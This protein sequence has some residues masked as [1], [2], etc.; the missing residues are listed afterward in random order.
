MIYD[1]CM[2]MWAI[3]II[4]WIIELKI[5]LYRVLFLFFK[6]LKKIYIPNNFTDVSEKNTLLL[7]V[8]CNLCTKVGFHQKHTLGVIVFNDSHTHTYRNHRKNINY[9]TMWIFNVDKFRQCARIRTENSQ[10]G[11]TISFPYAL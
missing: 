4:K 3:K 10:K 1:C 11:A 8:G 2:K 6:W 5:N 7:T 9:Y